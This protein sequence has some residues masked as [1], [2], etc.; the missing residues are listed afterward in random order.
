MI[1]FNVQGLPLLPSSIY[2]KALLPDF[3]AADCASYARARFQSTRAR[4]TDFST[5][6]QFHLIAVE[7]VFT[8]KNLNYLF[9]IELLYSYS[10]EGIT[11]CPMAIIGS[12][13]KTLT[14]SRRDEEEY[15][16][17]SIHDESAQRERGE[18]VPHS[19]NCRCCGS[20]AVAV[21][22]AESLSA[23]ADAHTD[24]LIIA[25]SDV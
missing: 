10:P 19:N 20:Q 15:R 25:A 1:G 7:Y 24:P 9:Y 3:Y 12:A 21:Y 16:P 5:T 11:D 17:H 23:R 8:S 13:K 14:D 6:A 22:S 2:Y 18:R 4:A